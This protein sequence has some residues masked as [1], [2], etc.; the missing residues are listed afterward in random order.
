MNK[1][2]LIITQYYSIGGLETY[3]DTQV[4]DLVAQGY[5]VHLMSA[6]VADSTLLPE[7]LSSY[8][9]NADLN[10][11]SIG[12][13]SQAIDSIRRVIKEKNIDLV[14]VHPFDCIF[15]AV[16]AAD[17][18]KVPS[19]LTLH[20]P[21]S[22]Q[23][24]TKNIYNQALAIYFLK[25]LQTIF[26]VSQE[27]ADQLAEI[28]DHP[29]VMIIPNLINDNQVQN[30]KIESAEN[31]NWLIA[32]RLDSDKSDGIIS[33]IDFASRCESIDGLDIYGAGDHEHLIRT[34]VSDND[35]SDWVNFKGTVSNI[36]AVMKNYAGFAGMGR[37]VLEA[38][39]SHIPICLVGYDG[40][41]G[42]LDDELFKQAAYCNFSGRNLS[43][44]DE[45]QLIA[46]FSSARPISPSLL[47]HHQSKGRW[48]QIFES[49]PTPDK[50]RYDN[51]DSLSL[52]QRLAEAST[53]QNDENYLY[54]NEFITTIFKTVANRLLESRAIT[55]AH[56]EIL[57]ENV[58]MKNKLDKE[59]GALQSSTDIPPNA[60]Q[61]VMAKLS[62]IEKQNQSLQQDVKSLVQLLTSMAEQQNQHTQTQAQAVGASSMQ[63]IRYWL[64]LAGQA[65]TR[66]EKRYELAKTLYWKLPE[67]LRVKLHS[68][69]HRYVQKYFQYRCDAAATEIT[70]P[71]NLPAWLLEL[72]KAEKVVFIPC[73]FEFDELVN[74]RP[75]NAAKYFAEK[76][77]KVIFIA[78]QW[79]PQES[80]SKGCSQVWKNVYQVPLYEF[81]NQT[82]QCN[83]NGKTALFIIT[84]PAQVFIPAIY[85][86]RMQGCHIAYDIMDEWECFNQV[87][88]APWYLRE[89]EETIVLQ[90]DYVCGVAPSLRDKFA[91]L[92]SDIEVIG[93][94][95]SENVLGDTRNI[96]QSTSNKV[97][98]FG[99][100]TDSWFDWEIIFKLA[101]HY[102]QHH[103]EIIGYGEPEW[104]IERVKKF[105]N[106]VLIG[107]VMPKDLHQ[108]VKEWSIGLIPFK[109]GEL[110]Q[111]V[112]P[113]KIYEYLYF[114][115]PT[116]VTGIEHIKRYP[117]TYFSD[118][119]DIIEMFKKTLSCERLSSE[120]ETFLQ[121][122]TWAARF[123]KMESDILNKNGIGELYAS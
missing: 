63:K 16:I 25:T 18:E 58:G 47:N 3:I 76:G 59:M 19:L 43:N 12:Q 89:A 4:K 65:A 7:E 112:D 114:G 28:I 21:L 67:P 23:H 104:V 70:A 115:L 92:R 118:G 52:Y 39:F 83:L 95:Y 108:Y 41:K 27:T 84:L 54:T 82:K 53:S 38:G 90:S 119:S 15:P 40:I 71:E 116:L 8:H 110:A 73:S 103:F 113:I 93:N 13:L 34:Y 61:S 74:Q 57:T 62:E 99:H 37:G 32:S 36:P 68:Q 35:Y 2:I 75:I 121:E 78:W 77:Y 5:Q 109:S 46:E 56:D 98:Y 81:V 86:F 22:L 50:E 123:K 42:I 31:K 96:A 91:T 20:G 44:V 97:G 10:I 26:C 48:S 88:Q 1:S 94:G 72:N 120:L 111:A 102:P 60:E 45:E 87:G 9:E 29:S 17:C 79:T 30:A 101:E 11:G 80:L 14:H 55:T 66:P 49:L 33:F 117:M 64:Q 107:K 6:A 24:F 106:I 105:A 100:L 122:T 85:D 69:R 51:S